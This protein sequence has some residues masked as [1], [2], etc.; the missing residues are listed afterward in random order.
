MRL[1]PVVDAKTKAPKP[2]PADPIYFD[3]R[4]SK[5]VDFHSFRRAYNT[6]LARAGVNMC[7]FRP[8]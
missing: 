7:A 3:T 4:V 2:N 8:S 5:K 1:P 6:A